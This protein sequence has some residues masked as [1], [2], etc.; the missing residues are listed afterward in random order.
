MMNLATS[1]TNTGAEI[2]ALLY[3]ALKIFGLAAV[4]V[5]GFME[6]KKIRAKI[7]EKKR[8]KNMVDFSSNGDEKNEDT[9]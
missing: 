5:I 9:K 3:M 4:I 8:L 1:T 6:A 2:A 7:L